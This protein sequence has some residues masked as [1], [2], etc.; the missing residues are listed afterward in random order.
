M[1]TNYPSVGY[2]GISLKILHILSLLFKHNSFCSLMLEH[3]A[4]PLNPEIIKKGL[5]PNESFLEAIISL[6]EIDQIRKEKVLLF[7]F[8]ESLFNIVNNNYCKSI[9]TLF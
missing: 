7:F 2:K 1:V 3:T 6:L 8:I 9:H 5:Q 4:E